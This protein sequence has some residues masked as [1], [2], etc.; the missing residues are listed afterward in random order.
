MHADDLVQQLCGDPTHVSFVRAISRSLGQDA[1]QL[2]VAR[3]SLASE[4]IADDCGDFAWFVSPARRLVPEP[5]LAPSAFSK[6]EHDV[7]SLAVFHGSFCWESPAI[8]GVGG[9]EL[10][11][12]ESQSDAPA[13][14][15]NLA[16][17]ALSDAF[18]AF[19]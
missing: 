6:T 19:L 14:H 16:D 1:A 10:W 15:L 7:K 11:I 18:N 5:A 3:T 13:V 9:V 2:K 17:L 8:R 4:W 12:A